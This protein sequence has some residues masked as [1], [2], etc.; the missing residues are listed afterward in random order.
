MKETHTPNPQAAAAQ[1]YA[2]WIGKGMLFD[3]DGTLVDSGPAVVRCWNL[4]FKE[5]GLDSRFEPHWHG[6]PARSVVKMAMP[7]ASE[8]ELAAA[9]ARSQELELADV[10]DIKILPGTRE[11]LAALD[12]AQ[13]TLGR[14]TWAIVTSCT[15]ALFN[16]R[17][18]TTGL[19]QPGVLV[20]VD[21]VTHGKPHPEPY[22]LGAKRLGLAPGECLALEDAP[23]GLTSARDAGAVPLAVLNTNRRE[24]VASHSTYV[25]ETLANLS[26]AVRDNNLAVTFT[27]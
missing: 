5:L 18:A 25:V 2:P 26:V 9:L 15:R 13:A 14:P 27:R 23:L 19:P 24:S 6:Q 4:L 21:D 1:E 22:R 17:W 11:I 10:S 3:M 8:S 20:T 16:A 12:R 7:D